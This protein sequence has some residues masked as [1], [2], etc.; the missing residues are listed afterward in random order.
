M[1][2]DYHAHTNYSDGRFLWQMAAAAADAGLDG[3][4]FADHCNVSDRPAMT[5]EKSLFGF[6]L[7]LTH[8][9]RRRAID[10][11]RERFDV[12]IFD[13]VEIDYD[14]RDEAEIRAFLDDTGFDYA[15]GS[16]HG[17][18]GENVQR[19]AP[20]EGLSAAEREAFVESYFDRLVSLVESELFEV[21]AHVDLVERN[22]ELRGYATTEQ[23]RTVADAFARSRTVPEINAGRVRAEYGDFHPG[24][25]FLDVLLDAD[26]RFTVGTDSHAP[27]EIGPR[28]ERLE[29][30]FDERGIDPY[31][32]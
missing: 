30:L 15:I 8:E 1:R 32:L 31:L 22:P 14:P 4:G 10:S 17:V 27:D 12:E 21:A 7:D 16:V 23:Y 5:H 6:N 24:R 28:V 26:V 9:R 11:L 19:D 25:E 18:D 29:L 13:A 3:I 2:Y 20:F